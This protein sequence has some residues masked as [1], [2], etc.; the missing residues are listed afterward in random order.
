MILQLQ[1]LWRTRF[2]LT[3]GSI[4][5][6]GGQWNSNQ[7]ILLFSFVL[8][9]LFTIVLYMKIYVWAADIHTHPV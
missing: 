5:A 8:F 4:L 1:L 2:G 7:L 6:S 9:H 3:L